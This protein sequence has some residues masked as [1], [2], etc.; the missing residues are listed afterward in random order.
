MFFCGVANHRLQIVAG[1]GTLQQ[2]GGLPQSMI[3]KG[4]GNLDA[5][6]VTVVLTT[7]CRARFGEILDGT[8]RVAGKTMDP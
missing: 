1:F 8:R 5:S 2:L 4:S 7:T 6:G 3:P